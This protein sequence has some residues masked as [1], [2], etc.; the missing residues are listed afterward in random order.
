MEPGKITFYTYTPS[1]E[2]F[3]QLSRRAWPMP[4]SVTDVGGGITRYVYSGSYFDLPNGFK[5]MADMIHGD[6]GVKYK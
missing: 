6:D 2:W 1:T 5:L 3:A 4:L